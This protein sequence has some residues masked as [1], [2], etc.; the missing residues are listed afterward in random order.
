[1]I[2]IGIRAVKMTFHLLQYLGSPP[3]KTMKRKGKEKKK[4]THTNTIKATCKA[5]GNQVLAGN[6]H[7]HVSELTIL[8]TRSPEGNQ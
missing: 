7:R 4:K 6:R 2:K 1:M 3:P 8:V 5:D